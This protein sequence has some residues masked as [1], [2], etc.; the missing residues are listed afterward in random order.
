MVTEIVENIDRFLK[1]I[2]NNFQDLDEKREFLIKINRELLR[3]STSAIFHIQ[4]NE[5]KLSMK[6]LRK[7]RKLVTNILH[8]I[9]S[10]PSLYHQYLLKVVHEGLREYVEALLLHEYI[11]N[12]ELKLKSSKL[13]TLAKIFPSAVIDGIFDFVGEL[14]RLFLER[15]INNEIDDAKKIV[16]DIQVIYELLMKLDIKNYYISAY[17]RKVDGIRLILDKSLEDLYIALAKRGVVQK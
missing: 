17:K 15:L 4:R 8:I 11:S 1:F 14:R 9:S 10:S 13:R 16:S 3:T 12:T 5:W 6:K 7:A 2:Y